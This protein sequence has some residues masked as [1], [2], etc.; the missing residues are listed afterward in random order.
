MSQLRDLEPQPFYC[1]VEQCC[2]AGGGFLT[3]WWPQRHQK[4]SRVQAS[5]R[6]QHGSGTSFK[7]HLGQRDGQGRFHCGPL[8]K[9]SPRGQPRVGGEEVDLQLFTGGAA[10]DLQLF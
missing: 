4:S 3:T 10:T 9:A 5:Q 1:S 6:H 8:V 7:V 2:R